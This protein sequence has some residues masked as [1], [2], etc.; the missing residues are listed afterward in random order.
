MALDKAFTLILHVGMGKT[1]TSA[2]QRSLASSSKVLNQKGFF[3]LGRMLERSP[4]RLYSWQQAGATEKFHSLPTEQASQ[5]LY[6]ILVKAIDAL[7]EKKINSAVWSNESLFSNY[8]AVQE[9]I[10]KLQAEHIDIKAV[11]YV[12]RHDL[13]ARSAYIQWGLKH[14]TYEGRL[15]SF[16]EYARTRSFQFAG[17]AQAWASFLPKGFIL[18]NYDAV[19]DVVKDFSCAT[20]IALNANEARVYQA[21]SSEELVLRSLFNSTS[22]G[23]AH[24]SDF[25]ISVQWKGLFADSS[26][27]EFLARMMPSEEQL[28]EIA[29]RCE[30]DIHE[31]NKM[32]QA[33]GQEALARNKPDRHKIQINNERLLFL[34]TQIVM[35]QATKIRDLEKLVKTTK[36]IESTPVASRQ[37]ARDGNIPVAAAS[38][39]FLQM[40]NRRFGSFPGQDAKQ[41]LSWIKAL[42]DNSFSPE[43]Q[44]GELYG[45]SG[46]YYWLSFLRGYAEYVDGNRSVRADN[47]YLRFL[48]TYFDKTK[49]DPALENEFADTSRIMTRISRRYNTLH[50]MV[51]EP[52]YFP[53]PVVLITDTPS[54]SKILASTL[55]N[56][57]GQEIKFNK[58]DGYHRIF[59]SYILRRPYVPYI[60]RK[61]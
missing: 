11:A 34:L 50:K 48:V 27:E 1:G 43:E 57:T 13:W 49:F 6:T 7:R 38:F 19:T 39:P 46:A 47:H 59:S 3:Y 25:D 14:K 2:I 45:T 30:A 16:N 40:F 56:D 58:I 22:E 31:V 36:K 60:I 24:P 4:V 20:G 44:T 33:S 53:E 18:R 52:T 29:T 42:Q 55:V 26:A 23:C 21:P 17:A 61:E 35:K 9:T 54:S 28:N 32:L 10:K 51:L 41:F 15:R 5:E 37:R 8:A 12:R